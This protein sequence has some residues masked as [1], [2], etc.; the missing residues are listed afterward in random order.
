MDRTSFDDWVR[1]YL[2]AWDTDDEADIA[3]LFTDDATYQTGPFD[4]PWVGRDEIVARWQAR[5]DSGTEWSFEWEVAAVER[6]LGVIVGETDY[7]ASGH[8]YKNVWFVRLTP[9]G[10]A[11]SFQEWWFARPK[12]KEAQGPQ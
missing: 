6:D 5:G 10:R 7:P 12:P 3:S 4:E 2:V 1:R 8:H 11:T 9:D